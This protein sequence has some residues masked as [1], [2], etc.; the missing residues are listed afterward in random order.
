MSSTAVV[1]GENL[2][3]SPG[4]DHWLLW[5][6]RGWGWFWISASIHHICLKNLLLFSTHQTL[7]SH[8]VKSLLWPDHIAT[9]RTFGCCDPSVFLR[10]A[11][12]FI[13]VLPWA[14][15][16]LDGSVNLDFWATD[17]SEIRYCLVP[18]FPL[19]QFVSYQRRKILFLSPKLSTLGKPWLD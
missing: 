18:W 19:P 7:I 9:V 17:C 14:G 5:C 10:T 2:Q 6:G 15:K 1:L 4:R 3:W 16:F 8:L 13:S 11:A 12:K